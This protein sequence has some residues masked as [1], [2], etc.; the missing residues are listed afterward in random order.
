M[1][2]NI[3]QMRANQNARKLISHTDKI[4]HTNFLA[5]D[6]VMAKKDASEKNILPCGKKNP[7]IQKDFGCPCNIQFCAKDKKKQRKNF[8]VIMN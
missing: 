3:V 2:N 8:T 5:E 7:D 6:T 4:L 1:R